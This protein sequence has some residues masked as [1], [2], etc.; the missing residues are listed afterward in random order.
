LQY[1]SDE[2]TIAAISTPVGEGGIGIVRLSGREALDIV[3]G[4]FHNRRGIELQHAPTHSLHYGYIVRPDTHATLDEVLVA[5]M[6]APH[7][8][9]R[10]DVVEINC[11]GGSLP[12]RNVL[13]TVLARGARL[14][15]PGEF[16]KR[17]FLN[18]RLDL[19]Q[20]EAVIDVIRAKTEASLQLALQQLQGQLSEQI[21]T[22]HQRLKHLLALIEAAVDFP[23][24]DEEFISAAQITRDL[25][26]IL[27]QVEQ[28]LAGA[29]EGK[30]VREGLRVVIAGKPNVGKSSLLNLLLQEER[31]IV[32]PIPGTTRDTIEDYINLHGVP[33]RLV[34]TAGIRDTVDQVEQLGVIRSRNAVTQADLILGLFDASEPWTP[35][36]ADF[37]QLA[38]GKPLL[39][40][41]NKMDLPPMFTSTALAAK[42]PGTTQ[43]VPISLKTHDGIAQLKEALV[44]RVLT[45]PLE[46]VAVTNSRHQHALTLARQSLRQAQHS[47]EMAMSPEFVALDLRE[48]L[49][50]LGT[51]TGETTTTDIL[52]E[53]FATFCIGK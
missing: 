33:I 9:T 16:T 37:L 12:L 27:A 21:Q 43:I 42:L 31:A 4:I 53:I 47:A 30:I 50:H 34:D 15:L 1:N 32:T 45:T 19:S 17:A 11:H 28:L 36:D 48:A 14:A 35:A 6:R 18:G 25:T 41:L 44:A 5:V 22:F 24:D 52:E 51:I 29:Q 39:A 26:D 40:L 46:S 3:Q 7:S 13:D 2:D 49:N 8:Y 38:T 23:E 20:A 10:E